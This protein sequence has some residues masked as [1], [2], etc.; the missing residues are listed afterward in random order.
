MTTII[1]NAD[2]RTITFGISVS[3][4]TAALPATALGA[5]FT[6]TGGRIM[7]RSLVGE[8]TT[9]IQA[10]ACTVKVTS[11]PTTGTAVDLCAAS[12]SISGLEVGGRLAL[13]AAAA[14]AMV[15]GNAGATQNDLTRWLV[16]IGSIGIT[17]SATNTG[18][19]KWDL[20]YVPFD[21]GAQV[22]AA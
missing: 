7:I 2:V 10:Q 14:T 18:S 12:A 4:A 22:V 15:T 20:V 11:T 9:I 19:V 3:R 16:P 17:T 1:K 8:V 13:P 5:I 21:S 6:V